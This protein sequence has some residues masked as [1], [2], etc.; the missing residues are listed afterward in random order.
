M[1]VARLASTLPSRGEASDFDVSVGSGCSAHL[2]AKATDGQS[3]NTVS[4]RWGQ[5]EA[6]AAACIRLPGYRQVFRYVLLS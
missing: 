4:E 5:G 3:T 2:L 6:G 1:Q